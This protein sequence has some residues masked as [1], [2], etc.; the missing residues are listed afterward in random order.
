[1]PIFGVSYKNRKCS[2]WAL[3]LCK[4]CSSTIVKRV[5]VRTK[6]KYNFDFCILTFYF[7]NEVET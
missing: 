6:A 2:I 4:I 3:H 5:S 7:F 1:M